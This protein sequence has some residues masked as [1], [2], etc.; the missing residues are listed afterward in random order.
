MISEI[1][2]RHEQ[3][4]SLQAQVN[5]FQEQLTQEYNKEAQTR[6]EFQELFG[7]YLPPNLCPALNEELIKHTVQPAVVASALPRM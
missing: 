3:M 7:K 1:K 2:R 5:Y 4:K 6:Q